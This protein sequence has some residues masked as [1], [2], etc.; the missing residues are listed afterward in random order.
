L[1]FEAWF[2][3]QAFEYQVVLHKLVQLREI[4]TD[5]ASR[6]VVKIYKGALEFCIV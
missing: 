6:F 2:V 4:A 5:E 3:E 1:I